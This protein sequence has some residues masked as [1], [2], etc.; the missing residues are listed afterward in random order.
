MKKDN[1]FLDNTFNKGNINENYDNET[2][3][4]FVTNAIWLTICA[5]IW[6]GELC[7]LFL[8]IGFANKSYMIRESLVVY[9][10]IFICGLL[11]YLFIIKGKMNIL[12]EILVA[13]FPVG[14]F[15]L[16][17]DGVK[18]IPLIILELIVLVYLLDE[19]WQVIKRKQKRRLM[20]HKSTALNYKKIIPKLWKKTQYRLGIALY[21]YMSLM[22]MLT[23]VSGVLKNRKEYSTNVQN[24][25]YAIDTD[26]FEENKNELYKLQDDNYSKL[27]FEE[28]LNALQ[29]VINI[30][31][32][33]LGL[34]PVQ[35]SSQCLCERDLAGYYDNSYRIIVIDKEIVEC[36]KY[37]TE[38]A[39]EVLL[40]EIYH[41]YEHQCVEAMNSLDLSEAAANLKFFRDVKVWKDEIENYHE[42]E[43]YEAGYES[44]MAYNEQEL[45]KCAEA[46]S[47]QWKDAY[48]NYIYSIDLTD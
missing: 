29:V 42:F 34:Y 45:E 32:S 39:V 10:I 19:D 13:T 17:K 1:M 44:Y 37:G 28:K 26:L 31:C 12:A 14:V 20:K 23:L 21:C 15:V 2:V 25:A 11:F 30:E 41:A 27:S 18:Y 8:V 48:M 9:T 3:S 40:H 16:L 33:Y 22:L 4:S 24:T 7:G 38:Y 6:Y 43:G 36:E 47:N 5:G 46:Y 35:L